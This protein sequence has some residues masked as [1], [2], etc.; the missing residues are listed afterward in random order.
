MIL[1]E[2]IEIEINKGNLPFYKSLGY[3]IN[4]GDIINIPIEELSKGSNQVVKS[5]CD[6]C[7]NIVDIQYKLYYKRTLKHKEFACSRKCSSIR[8]SNLLND[9]YGISNISQL[10]HV[11]EKIKRTN[12]ERYGSE[13][14]MGSEASKLKREESLMDRYGVDNPQKSKE[15]QEKTK[16][17]NMERYGVDH[18]L[19]SNNIRDKIKKTNI[20]R[21]GDEVPSKSNI[22]IDKIKDTNIERYG[23]ESPL[24][25]VD[26]LKKS[27]ETLVKNWGVDSPQKSIE[28]Q[29]KTKRTNMERYG[30]EYLMQS[31]EIKQKSK[32]TIISKYGVDHITQS[33]LYRIS[34]YKLS[35]DEKYISYI[36]NG[37]SLFKCENGHNY[38][39]NKDNYY[40]RIF[41][42]VPLCTVCNPIGESSS[43]KE[44][45]LLEYIKL[46]YDGE[47]ISNYRDGL[48]IDIYLPDLGIGIEFNGLYYHSDKFKDRNYH[49]NKLNHFKDL[50]IRIINIWEDE[51]INKQD[52]LR[53]QLNQW[54]MGSNIR[55]FARKCEIREIDDVKLV[56]KFLDENHIQ[57]FASSI[58][59]IGLFYNNELVSIMLFDKSEGRSKMGNGEYN[60]SRFC[61]SLNTSVIGGSSKLLKY[62][63]KTYKPKRIISYADKSWSV[64]DLYERIGF[65]RINESKPDYK[66][67]I[68]GTRLNK[69][70]FRKSNTG[71]SESNNNLLKV[72]DCGKIKFELIFN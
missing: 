51:W 15:I 30:V 47:I 24:Q 42:S 20:E 41:N 45:E 57:G 60:L 9:Q 72:W 56:R 6:F 12:M 35:N 2:N 36:G 33:E 67:L 14:Y 59:K 10:D 70:R 54:I 7:G 32:D 11:R 71:I 29:K 3:S 8:N 25:N 16:K 38:E 37:V 43:I 62:F 5:K 18:V 19:Q 34:N 69:S 17:T 28:I 61:N 65:D 39:I 46:I 21:Y 4:M 68:K 55:I 48:E 23:Y 31:D 40:N 13:S 66:Y 44:K 58:V 63:I 50:G 27:K 1:T 49:L 22:V 53:S 64:G 52:I 26:I